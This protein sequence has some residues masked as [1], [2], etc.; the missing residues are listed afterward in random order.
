MEELTL[1]SPKIAA[2][3]RDSPDFTKIHQII[4]QY[5]VKYRKDLACFKENPL[6][7]A[8]LK[9]QLGKHILAL[10]RVVEEEHEDP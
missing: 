9:E 5:L 6:S 4:Q 7:L 8:A 10:Y 3:F 2:D 1:I